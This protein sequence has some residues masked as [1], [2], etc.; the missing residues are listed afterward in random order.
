MGKLS[1]LVCAVF[2]LNS[3][4]ASH[5]GPKLIEADGATYVASQGGHLG[6]QGEVNTGRQ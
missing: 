6:A 1:L 4:N 5:A 3:C 2:L